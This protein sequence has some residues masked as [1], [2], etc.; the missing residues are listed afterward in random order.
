MCKKRKLNSSLKNYTYPSPNKAI[1]S[2]NSDTSNRKISKIANKNSDTGN[3]SAIDIAN[4]NCDSSDILKINIAK[5]KRSN[6]D[7]KEK[8]INRIASK[9]KTKKSCP[10]TNK[11]DLTNSSDLNSIES[12]ISKKSKTNKGS[13]PK[14]GSTKTDYLGVTAV[15]SIMEPATESQEASRRKL[16]LVSHPSNKVKVLLDSGSDGDLYF[17]QKGTDKHFPYLKRQ[18]PKSWHTSNGNFQTNGRAK[19]RVNSLNTQQAGSISYNLML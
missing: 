17:L 5:T 19:L 9:N 4:K 1:P 2:L 10:L 8:A 18:V 6:S 12:K 13:T 7:F 3:K 16:P 14:V 11:R 15:I